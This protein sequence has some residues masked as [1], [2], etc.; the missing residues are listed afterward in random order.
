M[1]NTKNKTKPEMYFCSAN[2]PAA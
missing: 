1:T 2:L